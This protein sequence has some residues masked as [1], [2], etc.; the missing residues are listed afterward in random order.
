MHPRAANTSPLLNAAASEDV[1]LFRRLLNDA[2]YTHEGI[3]KVLGTIEGPTRRARNLPRLLQSTSHGT[4][5]ETLIRLFLFG[6]PVDVEAARKAL[7]P[8]PP[9]TLQQMGLLE[10]GGGVARAPAVLLP[11]GNLIVACDH[12]EKAVAGAP[13]DLVMGI[14]ASTAHVIRCGV[15]R[16]SRNTL[17]FGTG[18]GVQALLAAN[19]SDRVYA[20]DFSPRALNFA[21]FNAVLN[22]VSNIEFREGD[23]FEPVRGMRF[24]LILANLPFAITP[25]LR[26]LYRDS[27][28]P[29]DAFAERVVRQAPQ[30]LEECG[31]CQLMCDW[32]Q[33]AG[34]SWEDHLRAWF[35]DSG[36]DVWVMRQNTQQPAVYAELWI[37]D[38]E[39]DDPEIFAR[40]YSEWMAYYEREKVE[41]ICTGLI[42]MR[43]TSG[44]ANW[45]RIDDAPDDITE[46]YGDIVLRGFDLRD[47]LE[48]AS[49]DEALLNTKLV[50]STDVR[51]MQQSEWT[52]QGWRVV[53]GQLVH[54]KGLRY[55]GNV[56]PRVAGL[57]SRCDGTHTLLEL[58]LP[59]AE[60]LKVDVERVIAAS[61][62]L[63]R[64]LI[65]RGFLL[66][67]SLK[68]D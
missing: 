17:D 50:T 13:V 54:V 43:R 66:P 16:H 15:R 52:P 62:P 58:L 48:S 2:G 1:H 51:L 40:L 65:E 10:I 47:F 24:D 49:G 9:E 33:P 8:V 11:Y 18:N 25:Q 42:M 21:R 45:L 61:L 44:R 60:G 29:L 32:V 64:Q 55:T 41:S 26:Y 59:L 6:V 37:R 14:T 56:D 68:Q 27:G 57:M 39:Q 23:G 20:V 63:V 19:H 46:A 38:T 22:N 34:Q 4:Q 35:A 30:F 53:G 3:G 36:C 28:L 12:L 5:L 31:F 7:H 67:V